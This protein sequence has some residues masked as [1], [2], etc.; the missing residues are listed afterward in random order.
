ML[1]NKYEYD[2]LLITPVFLKSLNIVKVNQLILFNFPNEYR[3]F[4]RI[5]SK[6]SQMGDEKND[7]ICHIMID[8][9]ETQKF[10]SLVEK[11]KMIE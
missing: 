8:Q 1:Y 6:F 2:I 4:L 9:T 10:S 7:N 11:L 5:L 3:D